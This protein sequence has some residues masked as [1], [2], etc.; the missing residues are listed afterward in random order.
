MKKTFAFTYLL[1]ITTLCFTQVPQAFRYQTMVRD[2]LGIAIVNR[3]VSIKISILKDE[4]NSAGIYS[5]NHKIATNDYGMV[6]LSVGA[7]SAIT[8]NFATIDW[9][10]GT[11]FIKIDLDITGGN[12]YQFM[13]TTQLLSVPYAL[14]AER[15]N[16]SNA[17]TSSN[18]E[19]QVL[20]QNGLQV[21]LSQGGGAIN[22]ADNDNDSENEIQSISK[23]GNNITLSKNGGSVVDSDNQQLT[24]NGNQ[25]TISNGNTVTLQ[26]NVNDADADPLNEIQQI[27]KTGNTINLNKNGGSVLDSD[28]QTISIEG[29]QLLIS[30]GNS[31]VLSGNID[32]DADPTNEL[33]LLNINADTVSISKGNSILLPRNLDNDSINELQNLKI[34]GDTIAISKG[35]SVI[36]P[37]NKDN[38]PLNEL[39]SL[40]YRNDTLFLSKG[41]FVKIGIKNLLPENSAL[42]TKDTVSLDGF[43]INEQAIE[44]NGNTLKRLFFDKDGWERS[45]LI[46]SKIYLISSSG[47]TKFAS[48]D[49]KTGSY[50]ELKYNDILI[51][52]NAIYNFNNKLISHLNPKIFEYDEQNDTFLV[53]YVNLDNQYFGICGIFNNEL[54]I[55]CPFTQAQHALLRGFYFLDNNYSQTRFD[56]LNDPSGGTVIGKY[57]KLG[58]NPE[59]L[60]D[61]TN[62]SKTNLPNLYHTNYV[63]FLTEFKDTLY[64]QLDNYLYKTFNSEIISFESISGYKIYSFSNDKLLFIGNGG[65]S[66]VGISFI[67]NLNNDSITN[68]ENID[69]DGDYI[70]SINLINNNLYLIT[71]NSIFQYNVNKPEKYY[72]QELI[73]K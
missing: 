52:N 47:I 58:Y 40:T 19:L 65:T 12:N 60:Y 27:T 69:I 34:N 71:R 9:S 17:D 50:R 38:D 51:G 30:N 14:Y 49:L 21:S 39:Q 70:K 6:N 22:I 41:N 68:I 18:N 20:S 46:N 4:P 67:R 29:N 25:L 72:I 43:K 31:V 62:K 59:Y 55:N 3:I 24:A 35:N 73:S 26:D 11:F 15:A 44:S 32:L 64:I 10:T 48:F 8:G 45:I 56:Y 2:G 23:T 66:F 5:E 42:L 57:I 1:L 61:I 63:N 28:N 33:Q 13:G 53:K 7:G 36:L 16:I 37:E 54:I